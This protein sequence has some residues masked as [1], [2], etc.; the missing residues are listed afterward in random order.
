MKLYYSPGACSLA[1]HIVA[2]E[3]GLAVEAIVAST[4]P[5]SWPMAPDFYTTQ[6]RWAT[7]PSSRDDGQTLSEGPVISHHLADQAPDKGLI[8]P[9]GSMAL[10]RPGMWPNFIGTELHKAKLA[11][12]QSPAPR[13]TSSPPSSSACCKRF[14][15]VF[16]NHG[17]LCAGRGQRPM[18]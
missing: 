7:C 8:G 9:V 17:R 10:P 18:R 13:K 4:K 3:A 11:L 12:V 16:I 6:T 15:C 14:T 1:P 2:C 5:T